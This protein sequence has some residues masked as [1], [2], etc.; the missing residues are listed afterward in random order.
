MYTMPDPKRQNCISEAPCGAN[1]RVNQ[2][3]RCEE[4]PTGYKLTADGKFCEVVVVTPPPAPKPTPPPAKPLPIVDGR[5]KDV[6]FVSV[7]PLDRLLNQ[8]NNDD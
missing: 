2:S 8:K 5:R 6:S 7:K 3:G 4:C 1:A